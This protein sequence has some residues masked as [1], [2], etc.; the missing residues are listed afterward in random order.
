MSQNRQDKFYQKANRCKHN[1]LSENYFVEY[2]CMTPYCSAEE[3]HCSD[4]GAF[5]TTCG[6]GCE[7]G[8]SGWSRTRRAKMGAI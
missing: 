8:I 7:G 1:N 6:C 2:R 4:C 3:V 5:I